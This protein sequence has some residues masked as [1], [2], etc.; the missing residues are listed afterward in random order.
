MANRVFF[1]DA[2]KIIEDNEPEELFNNLQNEL[3]QFFLS[4]ILLH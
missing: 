2:G 4:Q 1:L 3:T